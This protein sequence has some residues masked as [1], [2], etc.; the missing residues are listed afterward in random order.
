MSKIE[1]QNK[2]FL[3]KGL[4]DNKKIMENTLEAILSGVKAQ[5][6]IYLTV[7]ETKDHILIIYEDINLSRLHNVKDKIEDMTYD[8]LN[9][10]SFYHIPTLKEVL[11]VILGKVDVILNLKIRGKKTNIFNILDSYPGN[12]ALVGNSSILRLINK[13][14]AN[15]LIGDIYT[16]KVK[17]N[18]FTFML[19]TSF[20][21]IDISYYSKIRIKK[22][23]EDNIPLIG[24]LINTEEKYQEFEDMFDYLIIDNYLNL[25][26]I[27]K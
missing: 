24:Y 4:Y 7:R 23:K 1:F 21:S 2:I 25:K 11:D 14:R 16:K 20:R 10:L 12:F 3:N 13:K 15:Y 18:L 5:K 27:I 8:E 6:G 22:L 17:L 26:K 19:K 9:Y